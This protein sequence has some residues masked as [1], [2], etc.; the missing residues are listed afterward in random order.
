MEDIIN[1]FNSEEGEEKN[2][3]FSGS[4]VYKSSRLWRIKNNII[5]A[6]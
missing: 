1:G 2:M 5:I 6:K 4:V 3:S